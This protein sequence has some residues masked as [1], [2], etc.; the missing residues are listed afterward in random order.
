MNNY[1]F[2]LFFH[3]FQNKFKKIVNFWY[4]ASIYYM[5]MYQNKT[6]M[7]MK[8]TCIDYKAQRGV[9]QILLINFYQLISE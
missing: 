8:Y 3:A 6:K 1:D 4:D 7:T 2:T 9:V 5:Y